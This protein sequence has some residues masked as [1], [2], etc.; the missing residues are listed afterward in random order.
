MKTE[1]IEISPTPVP[2]DYVLHLTKDEACKLN[3]LVGCRHSRSTCTLAGVEEFAQAL[4]KEIIHD[5]PA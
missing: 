1:I 3:H 2:A 5:W 4:E